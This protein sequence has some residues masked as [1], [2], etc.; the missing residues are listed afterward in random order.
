MFNIIIIFGTNTKIHL[1]QT[2][3]SCLIFFSRISQLSTGLQLDQTGH[4]MIYG[5]LY[6]PTFG[7]CR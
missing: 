5:E 2:V 6:C 4:K 3:Y 1:G 7:K